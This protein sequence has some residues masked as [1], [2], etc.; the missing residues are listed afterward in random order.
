[1]ALLSRATGWNIFGAS[2]TNGDRY[3][4]FF[5]RAKLLQSVCKIGAR[6]EGIRDLPFFEL[7][8]QDERFKPK[9]LDMYE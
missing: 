9:Q 7:V 2:D 1:V 5:N 8:E 4:D 3:Q 6:V